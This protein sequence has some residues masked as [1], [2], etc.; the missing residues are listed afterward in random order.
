MAYQRLIVKTSG[1]NCRYV[2]HRYAKAISARKKA[3]TRRMC[4]TTINEEAIIISFSD[5]LCGNLVKRER[6]VPVIRAVL[7][8]DNT[9]LTRIKVRGEITR[10]VT[11]KTSERERQWGSL[12]T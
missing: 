10:Q 3:Y 1:N 4:R 5:I 9:I 2:C 11:A 12:F 6:F 8:N 7:E